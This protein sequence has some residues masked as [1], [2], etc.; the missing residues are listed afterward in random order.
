MRDVGLVGRRS[1]EGGERLVCLCVGCRVSCVERRVLLLFVIVP[2]RC[3][4]LCLLL[5]CSVLLL[6]A[7]AVVAVPVVF[8]LVM[9]VSGCAVSVAALLSCMLVACSQRARLRSCGLLS[10]DFIER[11]WERGTEKERDRAS[12]RK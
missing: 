8:L 1:G 6:R 12:E 2:C 11:G 7:A 5:L 9:R 4:E 10:A 3:R